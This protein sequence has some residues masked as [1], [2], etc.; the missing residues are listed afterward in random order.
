[1]SETLLPDDRPYQAEIMRALAER[2]FFCL[3]WR[4]Q[5]GKSTTLAQ[6][7]LAAM[8]AQ[9][10][11]TVIYASASLLL[12]REICFKEAQLLAEVFRRLAGRLE[13]AEAGTNKVYADLDPDALAQL[14]ES[15]R[16]EFRVHHD[17]TTISRTQVIAPNPA[18]ARGWT[19]W[20]FLDEFGFI[21]DF[22][23]LWEAV[24][25]IVS[26][27]K[28]F[29]LIMATTPPRDDA[30]YSYELTAPAIGTPFPIDPRG[31]WYVSEANVPVHRVDVFDAFEAG[32]KLYDLRTGRELTP[33]E[34]F[35]AADDKDAWRRNYK[36]EHVLGGTS[37]ISLLVLDTAQ[38]RGVG[39]CAC[40]VVDDDLDFERGLAWI[41]EKLALSTPVGL[42]WDLATTTKE[43]SNPSA[44]AVVERQGVHFSARCVLVWKTS[45]PDV[46]LDRARR[47]VRTVAARGTRPRRLCI[48][49]TNE[50]L[51]S[52]TVKKELLH[53]VPVEMVVGSEVVE[54][55]GAEPM[56]MKQW[57]G[58]K[59]VGAFDDNHVDAPPERYFRE[60]VRLV[61]KEKGQFVCEPDGN[62]R[63]G[64]TFDAVKLALH[65]LFSAGEARAIP[66]QVGTYRGGML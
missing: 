15:Q 12:G 2:R 53:D 35:A 40:I 11:L 6:A 36:V 34:H 19:G 16:L 47:I 39:Q 57:L 64:D 62:G 31:N 58:S 63:H 46:Q 3:L 52:A 33:Q 45:D 61:K 49:A 30:H 29:H 54:R 23:D 51:F 25:P 50:R 32:V 18:T 10:G 38:K 27:N 24:E 14:F 4:R 8:L 28:S 65:G 42:G 43:S 7:A 1:M 22:R 21:R 44:F 5:G 59:L 20:V 9:P 60:D 56:N 13:F 55:P 37:A 48:D 26:T 66:A 41:R 17:R